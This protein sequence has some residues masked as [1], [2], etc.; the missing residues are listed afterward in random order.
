MYLGEAVHKGTSY[1]G[2]HQ[3]I[4]DQVLWDKVRSV[5]AQSPRT[6]AGNTRAKTPALLKGLMFTEKGI[7]MAPTVSKKGS[8]L[9]RYYTSMDAIR[10]RA[11]ENTEPSF[12]C[13]R[14][15]WRPRSS[16]RFG[17]CC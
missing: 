6:R 8:R 13:R 16:S 4:I 7:A 3:A 5:L 1:P 10:N 15:W 9:Y 12:A 14:V 2:E 11:G 17:P